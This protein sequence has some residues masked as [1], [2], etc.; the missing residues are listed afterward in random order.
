M[1][2]RPSRPATRCTRTSPT[3]ARRSA[4]AS[5]GRPPGYVLV[6]D[7]RRRRQPVR[8]AR[9]RA[10]RALPID[11]RVAVATLEDALAM[12]RGPALADVAGRSLLAD[13]A[14]LDKLRLDA[15]EDRIARCSRRAG[16]ARGSGTRAVVARHPLR[17]RLWEQLMLALY[18]DGRQA[19]ALVAFLR[20]REVL[21]DELGIDPSPSWCGCTA[22]S[23]RQDPARAARASRSAVTACSSSS[24]GRMRALVFR[25]IQPKVVAT[26]GRGVPRDIAGRPRHSSRAV[27]A[28]G[29]GGRGARA[30]RTSSR[31]RLLA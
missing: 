13:A 24:E 26:C 23:S 14:R 30:S 6:V 1:R 21:A 29:T 27:R 15:Q 4:T 22:G 8:R 10:R 19:E 7:R 11:P 12:W 2:T 20:A 5:S 28:R 17:E 31:L 3:C 25:A 9:A 16:G 18:R